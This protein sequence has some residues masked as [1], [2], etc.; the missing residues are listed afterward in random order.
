MTEKI[1]EILPISLLILISLVAFIYCIP[2]RYK[3]ERRYVWK[4]S[5]NGLCHQYG[6]NYYHQ[7]KVNFDLYSSLEDC[8]KEKNKIISCRNRDCSE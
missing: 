6:D 2:D 8:T 1:K 3:T 7:T 5:I 4:R